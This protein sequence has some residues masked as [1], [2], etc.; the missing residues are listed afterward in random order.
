MK[1]LIGPWLYTVR[2]TSG[3]IY[4]DGA[5]CAGLFVWRDREILISSTVPVGSRLD[6]LIHEL[7][8]AWREHFGAGENVEGECNNVASFCV[9][10]WRQLTEQGGEPA[11]EAMHPGDGTASRWIRRARRTVGPP[12]FKIAAASLQEIERSF[13]LSF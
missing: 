12:T 2:V 10:V 5:E 13:D 3:P 11:V 7:R 1:F 8:H 4:H 9:S 6:V